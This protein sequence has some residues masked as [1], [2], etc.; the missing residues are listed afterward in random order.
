M[1]VDHIAMSGSICTREMLRVVTNQQN[2]LNRKYHTKIHNN[3]FTTLVNI[4]DDDIIT[5]LKSEGYK[6]KSC[7]E[8]KYRVTS[9]KFEDKIKMYEAINSIENECLGEYRYNPIN[10]CRDNKE[11]Y[12]YLFAKCLNL[13]KDEYKEMKLYYLQSIGDKDYLN[14]YGLAV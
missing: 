9:P 8:N 3:Y 5:S 13:S 4:E 2:C 11:V 14:Y 12:L 1:L 10:A 7:G 6:L